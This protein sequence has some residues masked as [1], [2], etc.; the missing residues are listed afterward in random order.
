MDTREQK[1]LWLRQITDEMCAWDAGTSLRIHHFLKV[2]AFARQIGLHEGLDEH[3]QFVLEAAALTHDIGIRL[4]M[5]Q[6]GAC[7]GPLQ[8][9]LGPPVAREMLTR[10]GL[11]ARDIERVCFLIGHHH[12]VTDVDGI[13]WRILL[14]ADFLVNMIESGYSDESIDAFRD[15]VFRTE[16]GLRL[17]GWVRPSAK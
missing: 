16:E 5:E 4:C 9:R 15:K 10:L 6:T 14:E 7:P 8:E 11:D 1:Q 17:I 3:A 12:T 2:H 13:D